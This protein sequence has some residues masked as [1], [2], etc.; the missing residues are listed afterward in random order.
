MTLVL[1]CLSQSYAIQV[2]DR[3][4]TRL[5][6]RAVLEDDRNKGTLIGSNF[7][8]GYSG[9]AKLEGMNTDV[10]LAEVAP[11]RSDHR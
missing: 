10:S 3:R 9:L 4:I 11:R 5:S 6:D 7:G 8:L 1:G 2:S